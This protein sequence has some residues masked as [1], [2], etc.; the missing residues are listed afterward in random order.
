MHFVTAY[1]DRRLNEDEGSID[2]AGLGVTHVDGSTEVDLRV[3]SP[4]GDD[5]WQR[6]VKALRDK[7]PLIVFS[8]S[9]C[10]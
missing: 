3:F 9:Y 2:V 4:G 6:H 7:H 1:P 5:D 8:K 10:P